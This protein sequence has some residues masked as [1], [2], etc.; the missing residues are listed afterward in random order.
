MEVRPS[1]SL[2]EPRC[3]ARTP[4]GVLPRNPGAAQAVTVEIISR[5]PGPGGIRSGAMT[6]FDEPRSFARTPPAR[7]TRR[8]SRSSRSGTT[9]ATSAMTF[10]AGRVLVLIHG[11]ESSE[12]SSAGFKKANPRIYW[13]R[14]TQLRNHGLV[15]DYKEVDLTDPWQFAR[16]ELPRRRRQLDRVSYVKRDDG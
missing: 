4:R 8:I 2:S 7:P 3:I 13:R 5:T 16:D 9:P 6:S 1:G 14:L 12:K 10:A 11:T 15:H